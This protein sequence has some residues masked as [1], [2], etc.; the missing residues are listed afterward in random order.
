[1][2]RSDYKY[3]SAN[4]IEYSAVPSL[5]CDLLYRSVLY[6]TYCVTTND[7]LVKLFSM[8]LDITDT[9]SE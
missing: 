8:P 1:M 4:R 2:M 5:C 3:Q 9:G 7:G 6:H